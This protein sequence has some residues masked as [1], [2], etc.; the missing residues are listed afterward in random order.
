MQIQLL[1][2]YYLTERNK[3]FMNKKILF[4]SVGLLAG[5]VA[6]PPE[7]HQTAEV[8]QQ[9]SAVIESA[10][11]VFDSG[12]REEASIILKTLE[13][14]G[15]LRIIARLGMCYYN[16]K[17]LKK[18]YE[19]FRKAEASPDGWGIYGLA[20][21]YAEG[22][23]VKKDP[24]QAEKLFQIACEKGVIYA[25]G[26][27]GFIALQKNK[28]E[29]AREYFLKEYNS[30]QLPQYWR[31]VAAGM[32]GILSKNVKEKIAYWEKAALYGVPEYCESL[33][34]LYNSGKE[35]EVDPE[36]ALALAEAYAAL[37]NKDI[38]A[39]LAFEI[40][41]EKL[42]LREIE[43][44]EKYMRIAADNNDSRAYWYAFQ[45]TQ[46]VKYAI[47]AAESG[48]KRAYNEAGA[49][50]MS[51]KQSTAAEKALAL[52]YYQLASQNEDTEGFHA[53]CNMAALYAGNPQDPESMQ[54]TFDLYK[55]AADWNF[56]RGLR[57]LA[58]AYILKNYQDLPDNE[59]YQNMLRVLENIAAA[60]F[61]GDKHAEQMLDDFADSAKELADTPEGKFFLGTK[62]LVELRKVTD[63]PARFTEAINLIKES[64]QSGTTHANLLLALID[65]NDVNLPK[66]LTQEVEYLRKASQKGNLFAKLLLTNNQ[67]MDI[68]SD[69]ERKA[70]LQELIKS[71]S[72]I[73][74]DRY[75]ELLAIQNDTDQAIKLF[76]ENAAAGSVKSMMNLYY[77]LSSSQDAELQKEA[78][79]YLS[80]ALEENDGQAQCLFGFFCVNSDAT[81][82]RHNVITIMKGIIDEA[83]DMAKFTCNIAHC[84]T[85]GYG[86]KKSPETAEKI[87][88]DLIQQDC[89]EAYCT[90]A[91][92]YQSGVLGKVDLQKAR[93]YYRRS[94]ERGCEDCK[95]SLQ[96]LGN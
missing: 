90:L 51:N 15:D 81:Y 26:D 44:A 42:F 11:K 22:I 14:S 74:K 80:K 69:S 10:I 43:A 96:K 29:E 86:V 94:A 27:L 75:A 87:L 50:I 36:K 68:V 82:P 56:P 17:N 30:E 33:I 3:W 37:G 64:A 92:M 77:M 46:D 28:P 25:Y 53:I 49:A 91:Y 72:R 23:E 84:Y 13:N 88:L 57:G 83:D 5:C 93:E 4:L 35:I 76:R 20:I 79:N 19:C 58:L 52:K 62:K 63:D 59:K 7:N 89:D 8:V 39:A 95:K 71:G 31:G 40:A 70:L 61:M 6:V 47:K 1:H 78:A 21:C 66:T 18:A 73:A 2:L 24:K 85:N 41:I 38:Y 54:K 12:E 45:L 48:D 9:D 16:E 34:N 32:L 60:A 67:Y 65:R 55:F